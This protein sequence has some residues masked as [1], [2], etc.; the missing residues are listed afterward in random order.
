MCDV[1][2]EAKWKPTGSFGV[3]PCLI[4]WKHP[5]FLPVSIRASSMQI[6]KKLDGSTAQASFLPAVGQ[7]AR[8]CLVR[9]LDWRDENQV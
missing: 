8:L 5:R 9:V 1:K 6:L 2:Q 4:F 7:T 3:R